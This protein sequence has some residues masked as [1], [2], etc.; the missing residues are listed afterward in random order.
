MASIYDLFQISPE[1]AEAFRYAGQLTPA[2]RSVMQQRL[3]ERQGVQGVEGLGR[4]ALGLPQPP[5]ADRQSAAAELTALAQRVRPGTEEFYAAAIPILQKYNLPAEAEAMEKQRLALETARVGASPILKWQLDKDRLLKRPDAASPNVQAAIAA[6]DHKLA[7]EGVRAEGGSDP[8]FIKLYDHYQAAIKVGDTA[9]AAAIK[10]EIDARRAKQSGEKPMS[11][12]ERRRVEVAERREDRAEKKDEAKAADAEKAAWDALEANT[13][14]IDEEIRTVQ[15]LREHPGRFK[16]IG[17]VYGALPLA[18]VAVRSGGAGAIYAQLEGQTFSRALQ[19]LK[20][21]SKTGASGLGQLTENEGNKIQT[22]K[23]AINRQ[24]PDAQ[25][26]R[27]L[28]DYIRQLQDSRAKFAGA[29][30]QTGRTVP[31]SAPPVSDRPAVTAPVAAPAA[32]P[33][34]RFRTVTPPR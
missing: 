5:Q 27:T 28:D 25:F 23:A 29:L 14:A 15:R 21:T 33:G 8:E 17:D 24:Q 22:A 18:V 20:A 31:I 4:T 16:I 13:K 2:E 34:R 3:Y 10:E 11:E 19:E 7:Q 32:T 26:D 12:A 9:R 6:I 1:E 30:A